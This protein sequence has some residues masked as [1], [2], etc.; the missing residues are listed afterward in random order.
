M[1]VGGFENAGEGLQQRLGAYQIE[2]EL[3]RGGMGSVYLATRADEQ[4]QKQVAI[5]M[6]KRGT[7]TDEEAAL[8]PQRL[9]VLGLTAREA[10]VLHWMAEGKSNADIASI[11]QISSRTVEKH[12][13]AIYAKLGVETRTAALL[14]AV[15]V[16]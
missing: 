1:S 12:I 3:G 5:K 14:R 4:F 16:T 11:L 9:R 6:L 13:E 8:D 2:R 10:E 15:A 7:D